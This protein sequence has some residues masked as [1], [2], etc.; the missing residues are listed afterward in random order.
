MVANGHMKNIVCA[1]EE[2]VYSEA[3]CGKVK[4]DLHLQTEVDNRW[5]LPKRV[6]LLLSTTLVDILEQDQ[7]SDP[8]GVF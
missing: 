2:G 3:S 1:D 8:M 5:G 4:E 7:A 6:E